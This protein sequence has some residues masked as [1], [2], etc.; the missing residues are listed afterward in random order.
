MS[1]WAGI[2]DRFREARVAYDAR[3]QLEREI[4]GYTTESDLNDLYAILD[5]YPDRDTVR[6]RRILAARQAA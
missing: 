3:R 2:H 6:I 1:T 4:A 5:R